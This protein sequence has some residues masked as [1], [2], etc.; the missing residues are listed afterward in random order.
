MSQR[1]YYY[2]DDDPTAPIHPTDEE[3]EKE[4]LLNFNDLITY[5]LTNYVLGDDLGSY[6]YYISE[7]DKRNL[8]TR[9]FLNNLLTEEINQ[10]LQF[11]FYYYLKSYLQKLN[12]IP[13]QTEYN[14]LDP[15]DP[16][17][18]DLILTFPSTYMT[19]LKQIYKYLDNQCENYKSCINQKESI[20]IDVQIA[21]FPIIN[22][23]EIPYT[24][25]KAELLKQFKPADTKDPIIDIANCTNND[26]LVWAYKR[27]CLSDYNFLRTPTN[28]VFRFFWHRE[29]YTWSH[30][31]DLLKTRIMLNVLYAFKKSGKEK[32]NSEFI[33]K[34]AAALL[35][36]PRKKICDITNRGGVTKARDW[37][38]QINNAEP[39]QKQRIVD[40][41]IQY[42][43]NK[44][45][46][47][48]PTTQAPGKKTQ[49]RVD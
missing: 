42:Y 34:D 46:R 5:K 8:L 45:R 21:L 49:C 9:S 40:R 33:S 7:L 30:I 39:N 4:G 22:G 18:V 24:I 43:E 32:F 20:K 36:R 17:E 35:D 14:E 2:T 27:M 31:L 3:K 26:E 15:I 44:C 47:F 19:L 38:A 6:L 16:K 48:W 1:Y 25:R 12:I 13:N 10:R 11:A 28:K 29:T 41:A 23:D 37:I